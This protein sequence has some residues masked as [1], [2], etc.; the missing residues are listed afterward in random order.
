M[1]IRH[2]LKLAFATFLLFISS[3]LYANNNWVHQI[4]S[5]SLKEKLQ[6]IVDMETAP[7][8]DVFVLSNPLRLVLDV[9]G[10]PSAEYENNLSFVNRGVSLVRTGMDKKDSVR[11]V[12]EMLADFKWRV[13]PLPPSANRGHRIVIDVF[14]Y[15]KGVKRIT[16]SKPNTTA[17]L[18]S[19]TE[20][21]S[22]SIILESLRESSHTQ[23]HTKNSAVSA[24][25]TKVTAKKTAKTSKAEK[26]KKTKETH[27]QSNTVATTAT[28]T[29]KATITTKKKKGKKYNNILVMIDA[30]HGG[31]DNGASGPRK[32]KEKNVTLAIAKRLK[33]KIDAIP[34][35][36][37][38]LT[39][40]NDRYI[41]LRGRLWLAQK[42]KPDLFVSVHA[43]AFSKA[44]AQGS[45]VFILSNRGAS[46]EAARWLAKRANAVDLKYGIDI[47]DYDKDISNVLIKMQQDA[48][49]ESS[50]SL[51][52]KT[53]A[54]LK[55][56]GNIHKHHVERAGFAVLKSPDIPSMLVETA[57]ITNP[58][59]ERK[60]KSV[61]YQNKLANAI[62]TGI[63]N[64]FNTHTSQKDLIRS[65]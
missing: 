27:K 30:G 59:E 42:H 65:K 62:A 34:G 20:K 21:S 32:T 54:Q 1:N 45:S 36:K 8:F 25:V 6:I 43:D 53:L 31:K 16:N 18:D 52:N 4:R 24:P 29:T 47:G 51:A 26:S 13:Y 56:I 2:I 22:E 60:L 3:Q 44:S 14:D 17:S 38:I 48:T 49:I 50:Y 63:K 33:Q 58:S 23:Q 9:K 61:S 11:I 41:S 64:Y 12:I 35:M 37:G 10:L 15:A 7:Q 28:K 19:K 46:S 57:F 5:N 40:H 39:R 55:G